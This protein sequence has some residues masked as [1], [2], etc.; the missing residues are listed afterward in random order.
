[1]IKTLYHSIVFVVTNGSVA[2]TRIKTSLRPTS[3]D[4]KDL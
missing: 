4:A 2:V 3:R 1:V